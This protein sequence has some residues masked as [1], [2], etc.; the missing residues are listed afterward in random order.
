MNA[1]I[2]TI[3]K[4]GCIDRPFVGLKHD[5]KLKYEGKYEEIYVFCPPLVTHS[6]HFINFIALT[7]LSPKWEV[8]A[9]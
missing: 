3:E 1:I 5:N 8:A 4:S 6:S 2:R 9:T 7:S